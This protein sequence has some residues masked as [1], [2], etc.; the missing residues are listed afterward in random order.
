[1]DAVVVG[2]QQNGHSDVIKNFAYFALEVI[3]VLVGSEGR[4]RAI[5][6]ALES[7]RHTSGRRADFL[8]PEPRIDQRDARVISRLTS[9]SEQTPYSLMNEPAR[10]VFTVARHAVDGSIPSARARHSSQKPRG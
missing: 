5:R 10:T 3:M 2:D 8:R 1:V 9:Q 6:K 7:A 4:G